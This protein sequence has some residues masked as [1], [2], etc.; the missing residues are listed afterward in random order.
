MNVSNN[1][2][3]NACPNPCTYIYIYMSFSSLALLKFQNTFRSLFVFKL[4][5]PKIKNNLFFL[6]GMDR[7][8]GFE[9]G[10]IGTWIYSDNINR[11]V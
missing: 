6:C 1:A 5:R 10:G 4:A 7:G 2:F 11:N 3:L 9:I 8:E